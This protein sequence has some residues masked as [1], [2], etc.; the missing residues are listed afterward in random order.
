MLYSTIEGK[1]V[2][3]NVYGTTEEACEKK[4]AD[5]ISEMKEVIKNAKM[6]NGIS[7]A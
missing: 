4:L 1:S 2:S 3:K 6:N 7:M 5:L